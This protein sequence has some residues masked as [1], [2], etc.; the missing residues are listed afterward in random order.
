MIHLTG[1]F[2]LIGY[3]QGSD[4][5]PF[6][7]MICFFIIIVAV[8]IISIPQGLLCEGFEKALKARFL[9]FLPPWVPGPLGPW[10]LGPMGP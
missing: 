7:R 5:F 6:G 8:G 9:S 2:P 1:D 3:D 4:S 10:A